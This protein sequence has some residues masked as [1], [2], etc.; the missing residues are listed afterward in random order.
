MGRAGPVWRAFWNRM[1]SNH[2]SIGFRRDLTVLFAA[3]LAFQPLEVRPLERGD[4]LSCLEARA[5]ELTDVQVFER[6]TQRR[7]VESGLRTCYIAMSSDGMPCYMQ[8]LIL[9]G[10]NDRVQTAFG[11]LYPRLES[12][13]ALLEGAYT[14]EAYRGKGIMANAMAQIAARAADAGVRWVITFVDE[15]YAPAQKGC[16]RAGFRPYVRRVETYRLLH[17][18]VAFVSLRQPVGESAQGQRAID[19]AR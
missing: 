2:T 14:P 17:R 9:A 5:P 13:E 12:D 19:G 8:W 6:L 11:N 18:R 10:E 16:A 7:I 15:A 1:Y 4:D 3:P